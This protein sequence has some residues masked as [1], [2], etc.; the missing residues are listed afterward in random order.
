METSEY[1]SFAQWLPREMIE[2]VIPLITHE[3]EDTSDVES[4]EG[5]NDCGNTST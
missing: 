1:E 2:E 4:E 5:R 3:Y